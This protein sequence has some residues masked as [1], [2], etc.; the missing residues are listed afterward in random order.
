MQMRIGATTLVVTLAIAAVA[1]GGCGGGK[2]SDSSGGGS[3][4]AGKSAKQHVAKYLTAKGTYGE[5]PSA[6]KPEPGKKILLLSCGQAIPTC[7][8]AMSGGEEAAEAMGWSTQIYDTK[9]ESSQAAAGIRQAIV[10]QVDG[11]FVYFIDCRYMKQ[12]L[13]EAQ[14][15]GIPVVAAFSTDCDYGGSGK[16]LFA[17]RILYEEGSWEDWIAAYGK[18][19]AEYLVAATGGEAKTIVFEE[20]GLVGAEIQQKAITDSLD[21][22]S[23]CA[24][25]PVTYTL[26][27]LSQGLQQKTEQA[28][29]QHPDA[30]AVVVD[31]DAVLLAGVAAGVKG[32]G[33]PI[34]VMAAEG[35]QATIELLHEGQ[36]A[37]GVGIPIEWEG[38]AGMD[39]LNRIFHGQPIETSG[40]G[41]QIYD[42]EHNTPESGAYQSPIDFRA[43]YEKAWG[44]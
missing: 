24:A 39:E 37:A 7:A 14:K 26:G 10:S 43:A 38:Y 29:L 27:D 36:V 5:P 35:N 30:N 11:V 23:G 34:T 6:P 4:D 28:L 21:A 32:A 9:G 33:R 2:S 31:Y 20:E 44:L 17:G 1:V 15:A 3:D 40:I 16:P 25:Y 12:P 19:Q 8:A 13:V 18:A 42:A 41:L 22:C